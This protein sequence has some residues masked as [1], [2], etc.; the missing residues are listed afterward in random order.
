MAASAVSPAPVPMMT[1]IRPFVP[2]VVMVV[3]FAVIGAIAPSFL[4]IDNL[5]RIMNASTIPLCL[6]LGAT[7]IILMGSI[8]LSVEGVVAMGAVVTA[9]LVANGAN[10]N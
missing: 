7:F 10:A 4:S 8:D 5:V 9:L 6:A 3:V 1:R 2:V